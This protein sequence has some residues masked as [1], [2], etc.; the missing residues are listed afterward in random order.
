MAAF[1][2][3]ATGRLAPLLS[4]G[5]KTIEAAARL[6]AAFARGSDL[7]GGPVWQQAK[8]EPEKPG[9]SFGGHRQAFGSS[10]SR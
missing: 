8:A 9:V 7:D 4:P 5:A 3:I 6:E 10:A 1:E 2:N